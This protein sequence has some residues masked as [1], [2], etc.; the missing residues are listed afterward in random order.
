MEGSQP[1]GFSWFAKLFNYSFCSRLQ[2]QVLSQR[3]PSQCPSTAH[4][5]TKPAFEAKLVMPES[6]RLERSCGKLYWLSH[7]LISTMPQQSWTESERP[8]CL[9]SGNEHDKGKSC[10]C[11]WHLHWKR[12]SVHHSA[13]FGHLSSFS[14][15]CSA[16]CTAWHTWCCLCSL[17]CW[18]WLTLIVLLDLCLLAAESTC[19]VL[20]QAFDLEKIRKQRRCRDQDGVVDYIAMLQSRIVEW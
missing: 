16:A 6:H 17:L 7:S 3:L 4:F 13:V 1:K 12:Y 8:Y 9:L 11:G 5:A 18:G 20:E 14:L 10:I 2:S 19:R 15:D